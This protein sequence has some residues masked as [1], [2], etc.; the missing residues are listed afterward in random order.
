MDNKTSPKIYFT[1]IFLFIIFFKINA[2]QKVVNLADFGIS[3]QVDATSSVYQAI[4]SVDGKN[5]KIVFPKGTYHFYPEK[6]YGKYHAITNHDNIYR[7]ITFPLLNCENIEIDGQG[8]EFIFHGT[9]TPFV[10]E[11]S[12]NIKLRNFSIDWD[13]PFYMQAQVVSTDSVNKTFDLEVADFT[14][15]K[16]ELNRLLFTVNDQEM[17]YLGMHYVF[18]PQTKAIAYRGSEY[19]IDGRN[20]TRMVQVQKLNENRYKIINSNL[21]RLPNVGWVYVFKGPN[22]IN[23]FSPGIHLTDSKNIE[24]ENVNVYTAGGMAIIGEKSEN[25]YLNKFDVRLREGT[26][27]MLTTTADATHFC[28]CKGKLLIENCFFENMMD[29]ACNVH[30]TYLRISEIV[31]KNTLRARVVHFQQT[32]FNFAESGDSIQFI[33]NKT[34]LPVGGEVLKSVKRIN[35]KFYEFT[36]EKEI[37]SNVM[38]DDG[39]ENISWY[40][41]FTFRN[42]VVQNARARGVLAS[43]RNATLIENNSFSSDGYAIHIEGDMDLWHESGSVRNLIIRNNKF[44]DQCYNGKD[45]A[46]ISIT[47]HY[48]SIV[49]GKYYESNIIIEN[50]SFQTFDNAILYAKSTVNLI[51]KNNSIKPSNT[52]PQIFP[53][54]PAV[55]VENCKNILIT[56]NKYEGTKK[57]WVESDVESTQTLKFEKK[58]NG[59]KVR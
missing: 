1:I 58:Q 13:K 52:Y 19:I 41:E 44:L 17:P 15:H 47:P 2:Q 57:A 31:N 48:D 36:F 10:V 24:V 49:A 55:R 3:M 30:G 28:N 23:R 39:L 37:P 53:D 9:I 5:A 22:G 50:N 32:D 6:A 46:V 38:I 16:F 29:D 8:S 43:N 12:T 7:Y 26:N 56:G 35:E 4:Q 11:N 34:I 27:R 42:N 18:D 54:S 21:K 25:I 45:G 20:K 51:F 14:E 40:P 59:F 33:Q